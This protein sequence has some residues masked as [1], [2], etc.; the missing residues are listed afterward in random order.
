MRVLLLISRPQRR[1]AEVFAQALAGALVERGHESRLMALYGGDAGAAPLALRPGDVALDGR[2]DAFAERLP[3]F[4]PDLLARLL[5]E[6]D[7]FAP[8][9]VQANGSRT[10]KYAS[11]LRRRRRR[12]PWALVYRSIGTPADWLR[13]PLHRA[14]YRRLVVSQVDGIVAVSRPTLASLR[15]AYG[16]G[17]PAVVIPRGVDLAACAPEESRSAVRRRLGTPAAATVA[18]FLGS[19]SPEKRL[20][21]LMRV[22]TSAFQRL[23][24]GGQPPELWIVGGGP[25]AASVAAA[26]AAAGFV[27]RLLGAVARPASLLAAA[28]LLLLTSDTEGTPGVI[29]EAAAVGVPTVATR[30]GG[31]GE[32]IVEGETGLTVPAADEDGLAAAASGLLLDHARRRAM[33]EAARRHV[34]AHFALGPIGDRLLDFYAE[35]LAR[36]AER[37]RG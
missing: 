23:G 27:V 2:A 14:L 21:R 30:V 11:L 25:E 5:E 31:V 33:G 10:V 3:G 17:L 7:S 29:L 8:D 24:P 4:Q 15:T 22:A 32:L 28:D 34:A 19:L 1:G 12:A 36:R 18:V 20:D 9:V 13:G 6:V 35:V 16:P 37:L 26:A